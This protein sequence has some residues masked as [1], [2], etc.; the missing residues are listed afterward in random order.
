MTLDELVEVALDIYHLSD[1]NR[2]ID[3]S[4]CDDTVDR[5]ARRSGYTL[6]DVAQAMTDRVLLQTG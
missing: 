2:A 5:I 1:H 4:L 3:V 6:D